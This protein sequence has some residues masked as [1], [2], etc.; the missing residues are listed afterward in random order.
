M[1]MK[2][3]AVVLGVVFS[4]SVFGF[5]QVRTSTARRNVTNADLAP[6]REKRLEAEKDYRENY[7][8]MGFPSPEE[9]ERQRDAD[10]AARLELAEQLRQARLEK[11]RIQL[12]R[13]RLALDAAQLDF[14]RQQQQAASFAED[15][16]NFH[17]V[18]YSGFGF[19]NFGFPFGGFGHSFGR[20]FPR[21]G[22]QFGNFGFPLI[23]IT[24]VGVTSAGQVF[25]PGLLYPR[26]SRFTRGPGRGGVLIG[27]GGA[28]G[29]P[30]RRH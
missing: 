29:F 11:E 19:G 23:R 21:F 17:W 27:T 22:R 30:G 15:D 16:S 20:K 6:F 25:R 2:K 14:E 13:D 9:L 8:R 10:M 26:T 12:E 18:G 3:I 4:L 28:V 5:G 1:M 24:P 7:E